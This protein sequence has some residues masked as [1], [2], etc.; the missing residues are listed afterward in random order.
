MGAV[1]LYGALFW[2]GQS[3]GHSLAWALIE[4]SLAGTVFGGHILAKPLYMG[5]YLDFICSVTMWQYCLD[6]VG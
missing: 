6:T 2:L 4:G 1:A 5:Y 3:M